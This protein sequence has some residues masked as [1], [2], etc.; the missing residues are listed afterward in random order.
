MRKERRS[1]LGDG[2]GWAE[3][4]LKVVLGPAVACLIAYVGN[5]D[6]RTWVSRVVGPAGLVLVL[7]CGL[8]V[9]A[10]VV[11][12]LFRFGA[13]VLRA[14]RSLAGVIWGLAKAGYRGALWRGV[15][16]PAKKHFGVEAWRQSRDLDRGLAERLRRG[17]IRGL[18]KDGLALLAEA[19][20]RQDE[21]AWD[22]V[23]GYPDGVELDPAKIGPLGAGERLVVA[24]TELVREG[25]ILGH[26]AP[27]VRPGGRVEIAVLLPTT[28]PY[29]LHRLRLETRLEVLRRE[30]LRT[31]P[32]GREGG[33]ELE[34]CRDSLADLSVLALEV[35]QRLLGLYDDSSKE[36]VV[37]RDPL[38]PAPRPGSPV[39]ALDRDELDEAL[40]QLVAEG[41]IE[42]PVWKEGEELR[43]RMGSRVASRSAGRQVTEWVWREL[44]S[45]GQW[46]L[47]P[48]VL[49]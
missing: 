41:F 39:K 11:W 34:R 48:D 44:L 35:L 29:W 18:S 49:F 5:Q 1:R 24:C 14:L 21:G 10:G 23:V 19:L 16:R 6:F 8:A 12:L 25:W 47:Q 28:R 4:V 45:R 3:R 40:K 26:L 38:E 2:L 42:E 43:V 33:P 32:G 46:W 30:M 20:N 15:V 9:L 7:L 27:G 37:C 22:A 31:A 13:Q 17:A 36:V